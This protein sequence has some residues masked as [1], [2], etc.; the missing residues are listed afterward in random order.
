MVP[1]AMPIA[2]P[3]S[4]GANNAV[5]KAKLLAMMSALPAAWKERKKINKPALHAIPANNELRE[6]RIKPARN[7]LPTPS[8]SDNLPQGR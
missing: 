7:N 5:T 8:R 1:P 6:Y 2:G 3:R 4:A